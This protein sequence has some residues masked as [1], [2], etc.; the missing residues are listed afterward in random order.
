[1]KVQKISVD[2]KPYPL[3]ILLDDEFRVVDIVMKYIKFLDSTGKSPNTIKTYCYHLKLYFEY[4]KQ[5]K[6]EPEEIG[7]EDISNFVGWLRN[8]TGKINVYNLVPQEAIR[9]ETTVNLIINAVTSFYGYLERLGAFEDSSFFYKETK[10]P[11]HYKSFLHHATK[12]QTQKKNIFKLKVKKKLIKVLS[13][14]QIKDLLNAC[15]NIRDKLILMIM[16]EGGLRVGEV[17]G[18]RHED[19]VSW[20]NQI[21][22][23]HRQYNVNESYAKSMIDREVDV[24]KEVMKLYT[25]Y[26]INEYDDEVGSDYVFINFRGMNYGEPL[27]YHSVLDLFIR[28]KKKTGIEVTPH[29]LRHSHATE[30]IRNGWDAAYI[31]KRLGHVN[32]QT[33]INTYIHL[34]NDDMK[35]KYKEYLQR[36]VNINE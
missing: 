30:L 27:K 5:I 7:F 25:D 11:K 21:K 13:R 14:E 20:D 28:L 22:I 32:V 16:Y 6:K 35:E 15:N 8:P 18:L 23:V 9:T 2:N 19:I 33:T 34:S 10:F 1:M 26:I 12:C 29:V 36:K 17:L 3:Y 4:I 31:Q 24:S